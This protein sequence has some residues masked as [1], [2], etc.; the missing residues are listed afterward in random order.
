MEN[1]LLSA[2]G[3]PRPCDT[4]RCTFHPSIV[5]SSSLPRLSN[6]ESDRRTRVEAALRYLELVAKGYFAKKSRRRRKSISELSAAPGMEAMNAMNFV[7]VA[8]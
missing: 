3:M 7:A 2:S 4:Q 8:E 1:W 5:G 6:D